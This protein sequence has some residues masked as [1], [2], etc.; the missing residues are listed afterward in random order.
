MIPWIMVYTNILSHPKTGRLVDALGLKSPF[1][2]PEVIAAGMLVSLWTWAAQNVYHGDLSECSDRVIA[3]ACRWKKDAGKLVQALQECGWLDGKVLHDW[4]EYAELYI[5]M[6]DN[7]KAN[8]RER[9]RNYRARKRDASRDGNV[10]VTDASRGNHGLTE[11]NITE[12]NSISV[13]SEERKKEK[14]ERTQD[15]ETVPEECSGIDWSRYQ[16]THP[17]KLIY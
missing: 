15:V 17:A 11:Q 5:N 12:H 8:D 3:Q 7:R 16:L 14:K 13:L 9:A 4:D 2:E 6:E 1:A 10:T